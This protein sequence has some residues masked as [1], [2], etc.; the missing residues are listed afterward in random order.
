VG[1]DSVDG[2]RITDSGV[3][4]GPLGDTS[5]DAPTDSAVRDSDTDS[6]GDTSPR[7][8]GP[9]DPDLVVWLPL[10]EDPAMGTTDVLGVLQ[11]PR[12]DAG[13][14]PVSAPG[15]F[16]NAYELDGVDDFLLFDSSTD[17]DFGATG[18]PFSVSVWYRTR[19]RGLAQQVLFAQA[20]TGGD[21]AYQISFE[22][23]SSGGTYDVVWKVCE[24]DCTI[25]TFAQLVDGVELDVWRFAVGVWTGTESILYVDGIERVRVPTAGVKFDGAPFMLGADYESGG[26]IEDSFDGF[27]DDLRIYRRVLTVDEQAD[28]MRGAAR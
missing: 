26:S 21:V 5:L 24:A 19:S 27:I 12:C 23:L 11:N 13:M 4:D 16:G 28:L 7:D 2:G 22:D 17:L 8:S 6:S 14:C 1:Y 18:Q 15:V 25:E 9:L 20:T 3:V 10:D